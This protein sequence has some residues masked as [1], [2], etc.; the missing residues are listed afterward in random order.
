MK[1]FMSGELVE[2]GPEDVLEKKVEASVAVKGD[3]MPSGTHEA[4]RYA[5]TRRENHGSGYHAHIEMLSGGRYVRAGY[6]VTVN[7]GQLVAAPHR[8]PQLFD[9][10]KRWEVILREVSGYISR[11]FEG[12]PRESM[13]RAPKSFVPLVAI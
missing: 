8:G 6:V 13:L 3:V 1:I 12:V 7:N 4:P 10:E 9:I 2:V 11:L 5:L